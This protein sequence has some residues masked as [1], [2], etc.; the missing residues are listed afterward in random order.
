MS[1]SICWE[2]TNKG[3]SLYTPAPQ[4]FMESLETIGI[5]VQQ[6]GGCCVDSSSLNALRG[7]AFMYDRHTEK[8]PEKN[9]YTQMINAIEQHGEIRLWAE[10]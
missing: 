5:N 4:S 8:N 1:A 10:Y 9:P 2:P 3:R 6:S 7:L